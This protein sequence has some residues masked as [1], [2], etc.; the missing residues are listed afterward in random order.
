VRPAML[1]DGVS[2]VVL[3]VDVLLC[4]CRVGLVQWRDCSS[5][6][7]CMRTAVRSSG[8]WSVGQGTMA[9]ATLW[10]R[11]ADACGR[12]VGFFGTAVFT[13][14]FGLASAGSPNYAVRAPL[15]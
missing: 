4:A 13:L 9:G 8:R 11:L 1:A 3:R 2:R 5:M 6:P 10:G 12:R 14:A 15:L 7:R